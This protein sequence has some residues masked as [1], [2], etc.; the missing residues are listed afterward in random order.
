MILLSCIRPGFVQSAP[1]LLE[2][3]LHPHQS[4]P[5]LL[6]F[7]VLIVSSYEV[8]RLL[9]SLLLWLPAEWQLDSNQAL[10]HL[11]GGL[12]LVVKSLKCRIVCKG[13]CHL[14]FMSS[15]LLAPEPLRWDCG[16]LQNRPCILSGMLVHE[17]DSHTTVGKA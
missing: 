14:L 4:M 6:C 7:T 3:I 16:A 2:Q 17:Q 10:C 13:K 5:S 8:Q 11:C 12:K 1:L 9:N 15:I